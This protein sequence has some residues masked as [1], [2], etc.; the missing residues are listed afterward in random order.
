MENY[1]FWRVT[2]ARCVKNTGLIDHHTM[3]DAIVKRMDDTG[4]SLAVWDLSFPDHGNSSRYEN[5]YRH[6][7]LMYSSMWHSRPLVKL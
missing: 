6:E 4:L 2:W 7:Y 3:L 1:S 5:V